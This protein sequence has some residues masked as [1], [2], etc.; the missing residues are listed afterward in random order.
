ME[1]C[2]LMTL[3]S[4]TTEQPG[5][6]QKQTIVYDG[7]DVRVLVSDHGSD[8]VVVCFAPRPQRPGDNLR[9]FGRDF[10]DGQGITGVYVVAR[11]AN[12][13]QTPEI[14]AA[15]EAVN[16][17][18]IMQK[19]EH[20][21]GYGGS[22][23]GYAVLKYSAAFGCRYA[24]AVS[25]QVSMDPVHIPFETRWSGDRAKFSLRDPDA[26]SGISPDC[27]YTV[28]FDPFD[29]QDAQHVALLPR[30][31]ELG[32]VHLPNCSHSPLMLLKEVGHLTEA[33]LQAALGRLDLRQL[34]AVVRNR[35]RR[36]PTFLASLALTAARHSRPALAL[37]A[38]E[39]RFNT[40][41]ASPGAFLA[42]ANLLRQTQRFDT[43]LQAAE[44]HLAAS[45]GSRTGLIQKRNALVSLQQLE[46]ALSLAEELRDRSLAKEDDWR[47]HAAILNRMRRGREARLVA[48]AG[49]RRHGRTIALL[50]VYAEAVYHQ[51]DRSKF[52]EIHPEL[53]GASGVSVRFQEQMEVMRERLG[54]APAKDAGRQMPMDGRG[55]APDAKVGRAG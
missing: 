52:E 14:D 55:P 23:G 27:R 29:T 26:R 31:P 33:V 25:P 28:I 19:A 44:L 1:E 35:R 54:L 43:Q 37:W 16:R 8:V 20:S 2:C 49:I 5:S 3:T 17:L 4:V 48:E 41:H 30:R 40:D 22:M 51:R 9:G 24:L 36:A 7:K 15:I 38:T 6:S 12:W 21:L 13:W 50:C 11:W 39:A 45:P 42:Y 18:G 32:I 47:A 46:P 53:V 34:R 10:F